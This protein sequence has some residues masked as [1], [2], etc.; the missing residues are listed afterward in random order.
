[1]SSSHPDFFY[2]FVLMQ[3]LLL[4]LLCLPLMNIAQQMNTGGGQYNLYNHVFDYLFNQCV[5]H[6]CIN[7]SAMVLGTNSDD[8]LA[9]QDN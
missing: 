1:M 3:K 7:T 5:M 9:H 2:T 6:T 4:I 8:V